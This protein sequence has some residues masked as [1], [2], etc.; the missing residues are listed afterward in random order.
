MD[1]PCTFPIKIIGINSPSFVTD[2]E[3]IALK[4]YPNTHQGSIRNQDSTQ[5]NYI[6][7]T[8]T[9]EALDQTTLDALYLELTKHPD[10]KM[11]L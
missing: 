7:I 8:I 5:G 9:V 2:I 1:F 10:I 11:V 3:R 4:H 6:A